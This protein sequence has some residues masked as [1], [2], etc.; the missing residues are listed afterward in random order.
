MA[1]HTSAMSP[2][3][4]G[5]QATP[6]VPKELAGEGSPAVEVRRSKGLPK[7]PTGPTVKL[8]QAGGSIVREK[9]TK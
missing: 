8:Q 1:A 9:N 2:A 4:T 6:S 5:W 3:A 7:G